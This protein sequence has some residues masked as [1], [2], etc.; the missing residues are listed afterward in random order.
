MGIDLSAF[1]RVRHDL[2]AVSA[3]EFDAERAVLLSMNDRC[4]LPSDNR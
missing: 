3:V 4:H 2:G 1:R